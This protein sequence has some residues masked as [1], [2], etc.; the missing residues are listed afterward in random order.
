MGPSDREAVEEGRQGLW[1]GAPEG[2][3]G[4]TR[5]LPTQCWS[6]W[7]IPGWD[8]GRPPGQR[9]R[10]RSTKGKG[11]ERDRA[12]KGRKGGR[13]HPRLFFFPLPF[14]LS[15]SLV[16][17]SLLF[18]LTDRSERPR[19]T[20]GGLGQENGHVEKPAASMALRAAYSG[21]H[22]NKKKT[23]TRAVAKAR[24]R[25]I[26]EWSSGHVKRERRYR[27]PS[28]RGLRRKHIRRTRKPLSGRYYQLL[29]GHAAVVGYLMR[30]K[31][32]TRASFVV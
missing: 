2:A 6:S 8:A 7:R 22:T 1:V 26:A 3:G 32:S 20:R 23:H 5:E 25:A 4:G 18:C 14:P 16:A 13:A 11:R 10:L 31:R 9:Q 27:L 21:L 30:I 28:G 17:S 29:L 15:I 24:F 19:L 12:Q